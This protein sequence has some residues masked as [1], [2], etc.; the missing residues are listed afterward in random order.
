MSPAFVEGWAHYTEELSLD[1]GFRSGDPRF[2]AGVAIEA[3]IRVTRLAASIG[4]H[5]GAMTVDDAAR[6]FEVDAFA[7]GRAARAEAARA[8]FDPTYGRYTWGK[9]VIRQAQAKARAAW[10][11]GYSHSRFHTAMLDLGAP[12]LGLLATSIERG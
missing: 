12:P 10:G 8:T 4:V 5:T 1:L 2:A 9:M 7:S 3:L 6:R 11:T